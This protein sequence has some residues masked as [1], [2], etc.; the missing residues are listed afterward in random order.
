MSVIFQETYRKLTL[1]M[2]GIVLKAVTLGEPGSRAIFGLPAVLPSLQ[3]QT[4][5]LEETR[6]GQL[7]FLWDGWDTGNSLSPQ[8]ELAGSDE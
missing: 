4:E 1:R 3:G 6:R 5:L 8:D 2:I 7:S